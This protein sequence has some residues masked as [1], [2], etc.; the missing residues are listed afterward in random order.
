MKPAEAYILKQEEP[1]KN[2]LLELQLIIEAVIPEVE[3][4]YKWRI[5]FFYLNGKPLFYLN[6]SKDYV[7]LG[8]WHWHLVEQHQDYF[9]TEK[10]K[11]VKSLRYKSVEDIDELVLK[12]VIDAIV[13]SDFHPFKRG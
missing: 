1:Y 12:N 4:L 3:M 5:P 7:D 8:F 6:Q 13:N 2:I 10:R 9:I 11:S